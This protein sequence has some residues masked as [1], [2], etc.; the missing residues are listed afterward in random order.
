MHKQQADPETKRQ[1]RERQN[2]RETISLD[3]ARMSLALKALPPEHD[4]PLV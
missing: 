3:L 2:E 1:E 4:K